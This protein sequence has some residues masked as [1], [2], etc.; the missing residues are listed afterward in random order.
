MGQVQ[1]VRYIACINLPPLIL[2]YSHPGMICLCGRA[3]FSNLSFLLCHSLT[4]AY[5]SWQ[6]FPVTDLY[7]EISDYPTFRSMRDSLM[8]PNA[9][10]ALKLLRSQFAGYLE[11]VELPEDH[12]NLADFLTTEGILLRPNRKQRLYHMSSPL[13]DGY[14]RTSLILPARFS[15]TP[16][17]PPPNSK[18]QQTIQPHSM[19]CQFLWNHSNTL[20]RTPFA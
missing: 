11:P 20:I 10:A 1:R 16:S 18:K 14:I 2:R 13:L 6:R 5:K 9:E 19:S 8:R 17:I 12:E 15:R 7:L 4:L 3:I